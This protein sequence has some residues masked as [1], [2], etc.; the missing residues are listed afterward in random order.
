MKKEFHQVIKAFKNFELWIELAQTRIRARYN[1][2]VLGPFWEIFGSLFLLILLAFLWSKLWGK[3]FSEFFLYLLV[4]YTLWRTILV[5]VIDAT[6]LFTA[7]YPNLLKN[8]QIH[9]FVLCISSSYKNFIT[10]MLNMPLILILLFWSR[11]F[12]LV[13]IFYLIIFFI[14]FFI[15]SFCVSYIVAVICLKYRDLEHTIQVIFGMLFFFTPVIWQV[16]Q[17]GAKIFLIQPNILY[18]YI[19]FFRSCLLNGSVENLSIVVVL[20][21]TIFL[22]LLTLF[23]HNKIRKKFIYWL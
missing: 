23:I 10:L 12:Y 22:F 7:V 5:T 1:R 13:S 3:H 15:T 8:I 16:D 9:P 6:M 2:T 17:L 20:F 19:N 14:L 4:G 21:T 11:E 18:H